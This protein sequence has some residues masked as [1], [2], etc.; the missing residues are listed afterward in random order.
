MFFHF[1]F[2]LRKTFH[3]ALKILLGNGL[4]NT[5]LYTF[6]TV[7]TWLV[8]SET[9]ERRNAVAFKEK[10]GGNFFPVIVDPGSQTTLF[11]KEHPPGDFPFL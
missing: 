1:Q 3:N 4:Q 6:N 7:E 9:F 8:R 11:D 10:L 2:C 5:G